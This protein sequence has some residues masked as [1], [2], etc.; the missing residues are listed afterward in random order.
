MRST[1]FRLR[2][3]L[4]LLTL[5]LLIEPVVAA[6]PAGWIQPAGIDGSLIIAGGGELPASIIDSFI[7]L[8]GGSQAQLV[9]IPTASVRADDEHASQQILEQWKKYPHASVTLLHTRDR[10]TADSEDFVQPLLKA[11][12]VW[13]GG[14]SQSRIAEAYLGTRVEKELVRLLERGAVIGGS[15]AGAAIQS[16]VMIA[17]GKTEAVVKKGF[18]LLPGSV[19]DQHFSQHDRLARLLGVVDDQ[20]DRFGVG[21]DEKTAL[22]VRGREVRVLGEGTVTLCLGKTAYREAEQSVLTAGAFLDLTSIRRHL[23]DR[24]QPP[25]PAEK[26]PTIEVKRGSLVIVG[27][28]GM[29]ADVTSRFIELAGGK[30]ALIVVLP[31]AMPDP[32]PANQ[33]GGFFARAGATNVKVLPARRLEDVEA[34]ENLKWLRK[35]DAI[36]F[37]GGRQWRFM[38]AYEGTRAA[39][40]MHRVLDRGGVIG[41]SSAGASIQAEYLARGNPLG[42]TDMMARG[43]E[44]GLGFLPGAAIDQHFRQRDRF[45]DLASIIDRYPQLL[46]IGIDEAT[47]LVVEGSTGSILGPGEVHFYDWRT[48]PKPGEP[49]HVSL[50]KGERYDLKNRKPL[51][52]QPAPAERD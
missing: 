48:R 51:P 30:D 14:G 13:I 16:R 11:S 39:Q 44:R 46:G 27:G 12:G 47:A 35:A 37:G 24:N 43:Y 4:T 34:A 45:K 10:E 49:D 38:D 32:L 6:P 26:P 41:G 8:A 33:G 29:P 28:G 2:Q 31:T 21:I 25:F 42:N 22:L 40:L 20:P 9:I 23:R 18:D 17:S 3:A 52:A 50:A 5:V 7:E 19:I 1:P 15:S 36:W